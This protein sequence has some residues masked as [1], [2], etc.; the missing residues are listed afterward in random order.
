VE[1][2]LNPAID[3][4]NDT[5]V[6]VVWRTLTDDPEQD[7]AVLDAWMERHRESTRERT[8]HRDYHRIY[9]N[10]PVTLRQPTAEIRTVYPTEETFKIKM[11]EDTE[12]GGA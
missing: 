2:V 1:G 8:E 3:G 12:G 4:G 6:L 5:R 10:G 11:F 7:A 9:I